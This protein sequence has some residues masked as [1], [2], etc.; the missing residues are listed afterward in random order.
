M[1]RHETTF[2][3]SV[4]A[5]PPAVPC[6][7]RL[8]P[9]LEEVDSFC[10][11]GDVVHA[12]G[13][14]LAA[15][16]SRV[17]AAWAKWKELAPFLAGRGFSVHSKARLFVSCVRPV[18]TYAAGLWPVRDDGLRLLSR[19]EARMLRWMAGQKAD[20][21]RSY[22]ELLA[23][24]RIVPVAD[25][26]RS[27]RVAWFGHML[28]KEPGDG[29]REMLEYAAIGRRARGR[30]RARWLDIAKEDMRARGLVEGDAL[31]RVKWRSAVKQPRP[32]LRRG[33]TD[34]KV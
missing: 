23:M 19:M 15:V 21:R 17:R 1:K 10:Y 33:K 31:D 26:V 18:A 34:V 7:A 27:A 24:F 20:C 16:V 29:V 2:V 32:T 8:L 25:V 5:A 6:R 3:C 4:C 13:S 12:G 11:L 22:E 9:G 14:P 30:P 28:R